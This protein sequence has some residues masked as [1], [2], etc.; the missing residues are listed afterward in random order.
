MNKNF[1]N[2][3]TKHYISLILKSNIIYFTKTICIRDE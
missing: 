3:L 1:I 2:L